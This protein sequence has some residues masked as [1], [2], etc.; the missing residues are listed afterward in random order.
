MRAEKMCEI[1]WGKPYSLPIRIL[2]L[3]INFSINVEAAKVITISLNPDANGTIATAATLRV[4]DVAWDATVCA[5]GS[6][7]EDAQL[8]LTTTFEVLLPILQI[9]YNLDFFFSVR[10]KSYLLLH[11][12]ISA[13]WRRRNFS[14]FL[15]HLSPHFV[16]HPMY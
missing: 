11:K 9:S 1:R 10:Q 4:Y 12:L 15:Q 14:S 2:Y 6:S 5:A 3:T 8:L 7:T 13:I 16:F